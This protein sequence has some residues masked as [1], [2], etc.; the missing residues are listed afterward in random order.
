MAPNTEHR[1]PR[2]DAE[3]PPAAASRWKWRIAIRY[4]NVL[5]DQTVIAIQLAS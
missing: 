2:T 4:P 3:L 5:M 1:T